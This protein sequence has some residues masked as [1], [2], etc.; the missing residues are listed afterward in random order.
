M[1][2]TLRTGTGIRSENQICIWK[3]SRIINLRSG[4]LDIACTWIPMVKNNHTLKNHWSRARTWHA[5]VEMA[6]RAKWV[7]KS[8]ERPSISCLYLI[9]ARSWNIML[10]SYRIGCRPAEKGQI[11]SNNDQSNGTSDVKPQNEYPDLVSN[12]DT[13]C[14]RQRSCIIPLRGGVQ[15][16]SSHI[17]AA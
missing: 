4:S 13:I 9:H 8:T 3:H 7:P 10:E 1:Y 6:G 15:S 14:R 16:W 12:V 5:I 2:G 17:W 11:W